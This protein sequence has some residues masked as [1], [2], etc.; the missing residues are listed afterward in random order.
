MLQV[1]NVQL[2]IIN[3]VV[4]G[5]TYKPTYCLPKRKLYKSKTTG[6][7]AEPWGTPQQII[8]DENI[9]TTIEKLGCFWL[10]QPLEAY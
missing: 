5:H 6:S 2:N 4:I 7:R 10:V 3:V 9:A 1:E 8:L